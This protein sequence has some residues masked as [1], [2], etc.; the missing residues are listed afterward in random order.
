[1]TWWRRLWL[2]KKLEEELEKEL[3]FHLDQHTADLTAQGLDPEEARRRA[4]LALGGPEQ[5]KEQCRDARGT[6]WLEGLLQDL[7]FGA[8]TLMKNPGFAFV[9]VITLAAGI[10]AN[11]TIFSVADALILRPFRFPHQERLVMVW[12]RS[13]A[14]GD[15]DRGSVA[16]GNFN[17]WRE[18]SQSFERLVAIHML[19]FD[20]T[21]AHQPE[22]FGCYGVSAGFFDALGVKP[23]L[24]RT[25]LP[26]ED[27]T[28]RDQVVVLK[29]SLWERRFGSD[30]NIVG[31]TL[32]LNTKTF[33]VIGVMPPDF[34]FP[35]SSAEMW[36]PL[37][38][39]DK[40]KQER[41]AHSLAA[42]GLLK[43]GVSVAQ[44]NAD[45]D[46]ISRRAQQ[47]FPETNAGRSANVVI[48]N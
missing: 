22:R 10:A 19:Y 41:G 24:R 30:P 7:R 26:D 42:L 20:L 46:S 28:G 40:T 15:S 14:Q 48:M 27:E 23:A 5:V 3:R 2:R 38:F 6:R 4:R 34:N 31:R 39:D 8:R 32:T 11:T 44:A 17:D 9:A 12:E 37:A 13:A 35:G 1:M 36:S 33:T 29:H 43:P 25:F 47:F 18:Q 45:L 16:P 21:G